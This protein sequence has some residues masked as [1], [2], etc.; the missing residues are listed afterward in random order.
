MAKALQHMV[1]ARTIDTLHGVVWNAIDDSSIKHRDDVG[2]LQARQ[3]PTF[4][5]EP[6]DGLRV[7]Q[8]TIRQQLERNMATE[9][10]LHRLVDHA[11]AT[12]TDFGEQSVR[13]K[14]PVLI[15]RQRFT[16]ANTRDQRLQQIL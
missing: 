15:R 9:W 12:A 14:T 10:F 6:G 16:F 8:Q 5:S 13:T 11:N 4:A 7:M 3:Q 1:Q 2:M